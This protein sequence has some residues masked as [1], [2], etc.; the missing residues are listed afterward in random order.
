MNPL[1]Q[2]GLG[3][4]GDPDRA[5]VAHARRGDRAAFD[6]LVR[7]YE[8]SLRGFVARRLPDEAI[9]DVLQE[10]WLAAWNDL[11]TFSKR[12]RFKGWLYGIALHK[13]ADFH[14]TRGRTTGDEVTF[15]G[16]DED[17]FSS[18]EGSSVR[19]AYA[20]VDLRDAV[21]TALRTLPVP[22]REV[23]ELYYYAH[24]T[25]AE[26]AAALGRGESTVKYQFYRAH[27]QIARPIRELYMDPQPSDA[28]TLTPVISR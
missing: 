25:L 27:D 12:A 17:V 8:R 22:Q 16:N 1:R 6:V 2:L 19:D 3:G 5:H 20:D 13:C 14:R 26:I 23:L 28:P 4:G 11:P 7:T 10:T 15:A 9:D 21:Q 18:G 24:L